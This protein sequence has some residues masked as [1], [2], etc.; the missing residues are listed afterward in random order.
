M[1]FAAAK[2]RLTAA[3]AAGALLALSAGEAMAGKTVGDAAGEIVTQVRA[4]GQLTIASAMLIGIIM[5]AGGLMK[6][7]QAADNQGQNPPYSAGLWR[8]AL[9]AGLVALPALTT[10][11]TESAQLKEVTITKQTW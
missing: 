1:R 9:G 2:T 7:K 11:L 10:M 3:V 5:V 8:L 4:V 6:L